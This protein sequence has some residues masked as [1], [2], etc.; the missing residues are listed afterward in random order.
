MN[1]TDEEQDLAILHQHAWDCLPGV[2]TAE[3]DF[4]LHFLDI[5][6]RLV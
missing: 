1:W 6:T 3:L 5:K 2:R 4:D